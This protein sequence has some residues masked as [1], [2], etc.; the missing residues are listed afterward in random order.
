MN[1]KGISSIVIIL[2]IVGALVITRE[3]YYFLAQKP[4]V[5]S[6]DGKYETIKSYYSIA[7]SSILII[8]KNGVDREIFVNKLKELNLYDESKESLA[9]YSPIS[10]SELVITSPPNIHFSQLKELLKKAQGVDIDESASSFEEIKG[11]YVVSNFFFK[12]TLSDIEKK[13]LISSIPS[14][15]IIRVSWYSHDPQY[16][17]HLSLISP[18]N[19]KQIKQI[20]EKLRKLEIFKCVSFDYS[21]VR[22]LPSQP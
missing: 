18:N 2:I 11:E 1:Q 7:H 16:M 8:V 14:S 22:M 3:I 4:T 10:R 12:R 13:S 15:Y 9:F 5:C 21:D 17:V 20:I 6:V 19:Q